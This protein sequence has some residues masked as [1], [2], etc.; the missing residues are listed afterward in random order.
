MEDQR[1]RGEFLKELRATS[2]W[3]WRGLDLYGERLAEGEGVF[4][5]E[6]QRVFSISC[7]ILVGVATI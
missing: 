2:E 4:P 1:D 7:G 6:Q 5:S 3:E